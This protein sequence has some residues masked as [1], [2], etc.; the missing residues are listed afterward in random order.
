MLPVLLTVVLLTGGCSRE[1]SDRSDRE[2][3]SVSGS[4]TPTLAPAAE[5]DDFTECMKDN[6]VDLGAESEPRSLDGNTGPLSNEVDET[7][8]PDQRQ[9]RLAALEQCR[10]HLPNGGDPQPLRPEVLEQERI[11]A[12]CMRAAG[13]D[14]PDPDPHSGAGNGAR[15][16]PPGLN[17][18]DPTV[19]AKL[20]E[21]QREAGYGGN[22]PGTGS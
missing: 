9:R 7:E 22:T 2:V 1:G 20:R 17:L 3:A 19:L 6:G 12:K 5:R 11:L 8:S 15:A 13:V 18:N 4:A 10:Q 14:Y 16:I 21:C